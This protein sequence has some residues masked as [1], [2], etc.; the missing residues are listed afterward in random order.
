MTPLNRYLGLA[1]LLSLAL[2][3]FLLASG[4]KRPPK[5]ERPRWLSVEDFAERTLS[6]LPEADAPRF[7]ET[8]ARHRDELADRLDRANQAREA[9]RQAF[10]AEPYDRPAAEAAFAKKESAVAA[11]RQ[12]ARTI[13]LESAEALSREGRAHLIEKP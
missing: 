8:L 10:E 2:N 6:R 11:L 5:P 3:G 9:L 12:T 13:L 7:K 1:L 4:G